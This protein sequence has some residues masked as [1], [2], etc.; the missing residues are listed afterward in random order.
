MDCGG[1]AVAATPLSSGRM[2]S[3][4]RSGVVPVKNDTVLRFSSKKSP[5]LFSNLFTAASIT[6]FRGE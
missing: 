5:N 6:D 1:K 2:F 3:D 4:V